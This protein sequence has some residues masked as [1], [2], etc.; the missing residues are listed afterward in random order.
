[1]SDVA[2]QI[3]VPELLTYLFTLFFKVVFWL[4][5]IIVVFGIAQRIVWWLGQQLL[6]W[7]IY[8]P[9][10]YPICKT[11]SNKQ[12]KWWEKAKGFFRKPKDA[13]VVGFFL[14][15]IWPA[16]IC[17]NVL[18]MAQV[19][20]LFFPGGKRIPLPWV[21]TYSVFPLIM[22]FL[23]AISQ[24]L[25]GVLHGHS[26]SKWGKVGLA[27]A[28]GAMILVESGLA[29]Y[30]TWLLTTGEQI[31]SPTMWDAV[32]SRGGIV[33][34]G[35]L[36]FFI[37]LAE[38]LVGAGSFL[39]FIE[40]MTVSL[41]HWFG[42]LIALVWCGAVRWVCGFYPK[43]L[44]LPSDKTLRQ[45]LSQSIDQLFHKQPWCV[46]KL[47]TDTN[48]LRN[49]VGK[50]EGDTTGMDT[51]IG[52]WRE[53]NMPLSL[54]EQTAKVAVL[55]KE[56]TDLQKE[57]KE[58]VRRI[59]GRIDE[60]GD[61]DALDNIEDNIGRQKQNTRGE[62][63]KIQDKAGMLCDDIKNSSNRINQWQTTRASLT[64][65]LANAE[66]NVVNLQ[67]RCEQLKKRAL[68][69]KAVL[70]GGRRPAGKVLT[71]Q[72]VQELQN[73]N[74]DISGKCNQ[75]I[76][77]ALGEILA[78]NGDLERIKG[79]IDR[80]GKEV[81]EIHN[82][83]PDPYPDNDKQNLEVTAESVEKEIIPGFKREI[84]KDSKKLKE[85]CKCKKIELARWLLCLLLLVQPWY[86]GYWIRH[87]R[88]KSGVQQAS[89]SPTGDGAQESPWTEKGG[90][91]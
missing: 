8:F 88:R 73:L 2:F 41:L 61:W 71:S 32:M 47:Q 50:L 48:G 63:N 15:L 75:E 60:A 6:E 91:Q 67:P 78:M 69:I 81:E 30:R 82:K 24:T 51:E 19:L 56:V 31:L 53:T 17:L 10:G 62:V 59:E 40:P 37:P 16:L 65:R 42:G 79:T 89:A 54:Q 14:T 58:Q 90:D 33:L 57:W 55:G 85:E 4:F 87:W 74:A 23:Y 49:K 12:S 21:G 18:L 22:G 39:R 84:S 7:N 13:T 29:A 45:V 80:L 25:F 52:E 83:M 11:V 3:N 35:L 68:D 86:W 64:R 36:G 70:T 5:A 1:M 46:T 9:F 77:E 27:A 72:E 28:V 76:G 44:P 38:T 43:P 34:G 26:K 20:E 66:N